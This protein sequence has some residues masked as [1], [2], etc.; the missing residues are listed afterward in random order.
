MTRYEVFLQV[1]ETG[2]FTKAAHQ[3]GYTQSA[4]S[5]NVKALEEEL[6][7]ALLQRTK[8][9]VELTADGKEYLPYLQALG[10]AHRRLEGKVLEMHGLQNA[11]IR[12]GTFTSVSRSFLPRAM[13]EFRKLYPMVQFVLDQGEYTTIAQWIK[14]GRVDFG[15][16]NPDAVS[17]LET[18]PLCEDEMMA[19][20]PKNHPL[21]F[22]RHVE[23]KELAQ[24]PFILLGE[25]E[26]SV[27]LNVFRSLS[28]TPDIRYRV[29][30]DDTIIAMVEQGLGVSALY[31]LVL[32]KIDHRNVVIRPIR[33]V[34]KR[35]ISLAFRDRKTL[36]MGARYFVN[37]LLQN[38]EQHQ[39]EETL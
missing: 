15:F 24:E 20:L 27:P 26:Y 29:I 9:R 35:T 38:L 30:D 5:Q 3:L 33:P 23:V 16:L 14:E 32:R 10:A 37:F 28:L 4:V 21:A 8:N 36:P 1:V 6:S 2:S 34:M 7:T 22:G 39:I 18:I 19:V 13:K 11:V 12:I 25:G 17:G 31:Q